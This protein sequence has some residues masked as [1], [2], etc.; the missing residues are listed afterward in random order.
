MRWLAVILLLVA[1]LLTGMYFWRPWVSDAR[2]QQPRVA[3]TLRPQYRKLSTSISATGILRLRSGAEVRVGAQL[4]GIV[5]K[6]NVTVG[7][8]V[9]KNDVIA[10]I[11]SRG[12]NARIDQAKAQVNYDAVAVEKT[13][14]DLARSRALLA[15]G[16]IPR[17]QTED[18]EEDLRIAEAK[19]EKSKEDLAVVQSDLPYVEVRAPISGTV[20]SIST[21]QGETVAASFA[22][23]TFVTILA[24][25][26][27]EL[28]AMVDETDVGNVKPG[29]PVR[30]TV[31][32]FPDREYMGRV[33]RIAPAGTIISGVVNYEVGIQI[34]SNTG[35]KPD[36]TA[37]VTITTAQRRALVVPTAAIHRSG[38]QRFVYV[39][40]DGALKRQSVIAG[41]VDGIFTEVRRGLSENDL[42]ALLEAGPAQR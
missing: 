24:D 29:N 41:S 16:L 13:H 14:Q 37:N 5:T 33:V 42:L 12:L 18:L 40:K 8:R 32:T 2:D 30:F 21:Q 23:P 10:E 11:D 39:S 25:D 7:S 22:A 26:A 34:S 38:D 1:G 27:L 9:H 4:S 3:R 20:S 19:L 31:E 6:L 36:M 15:E 28:V 35:L 17:Q